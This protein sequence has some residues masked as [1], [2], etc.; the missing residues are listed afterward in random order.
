MHPC[1]PP[2]HGCNAPDDS[3]ACALLLCR[4]FAEEERDAALALSRW[5]ALDNVRQERAG[6]DREQ[7]FLRRAYERVRDR[8][9]VAIEMRS[10]RR[11][12]RAS[13]SR[14]ATRPSKRRSPR[15][16]GRVAY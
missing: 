16:G 13:A 8:A 1:C 9:L 14:H 12:A 7:R 10:A 15:R 11:N 6:G 3:E 5:A 4:A 2:G